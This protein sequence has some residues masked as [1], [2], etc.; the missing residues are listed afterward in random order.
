MIM[1]VLSFDESTLFSGEIAWPLQRPTRK[2]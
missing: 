2:I 1:E